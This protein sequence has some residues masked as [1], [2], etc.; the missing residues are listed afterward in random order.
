MLINARLT[1]VLAGFA[2][3][4]GAAC[5]APVSPP[6]APSTVILVGLDGW[7]W[8][9]LDRAD[10]PTLRALAARGVRSEGLVVTFPSKTFPSHYTIVTGLHPEDHGIISN[11]IEDP[12]IE[13]RFTLRGGA[14][15]DDP[16]WW[17]GEPIWLTAERQGVKAGTVF[18]PGSD[19]EIDGG[20][21]SYWLPYQDDL[22]NERRVDQVLEWLALPEADRPRFLTLYFSLVDSA[23]HTFGPDSGEVMAAAAEADRLLGLLIAGLEAAGRIDETHLVVVSDHGMAVVSPDRAIVLDD[24]LDVSTLDIIDLS[25]VL[26]VRP[27]DGDVERVYAALRDKHPALRIYRREEVPAEYHYRRSPRIPPIV[28]LADD[29][30]TITTREGMARWT[31]SGSPR[32]NHGF[33]PRLRSMHGLFV[34]AGPQLLRGEVV[35]PVESLHLYEL[36]CALLGITPAPN[37]GSLDAVQHVL[38]SQ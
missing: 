12:A 9:Y 17:G 31:T 22:P 3:L 36:M 4:V 14:I 28:G 30:W 16:R 2:L 38:R 11:S 20:R 21:P 34:A 29:G 24:Y 35:P 13:G 37:S 27:K 8:D 7:R 33:D 1:A 10:A 23:G 19:V 25:P 32:G 6:T 5:A 15:R 18:W 26:G